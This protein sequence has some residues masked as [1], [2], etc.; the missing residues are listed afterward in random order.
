MLA[1]GG[2]MAADAF[3]E[4][5]AAFQTKQSAEATQEQLKKAVAAPLG[6]ESLA[7]VLPFVGPDW[8]FC[9]T[10]PPTDEKAWF[11]SMLFAL[12]VAAGDPA[13]P[14][15]R[16]IFRL[17]DGYSSL[18]LMGLNRM[19][20]DTVSLKTMQQNSLE[21]RYFASANGQ[22]MGL[23]PAFGLCDGF[24]VIGSTPETLKRFAATRPVKGKL[25]E[26]P[27]LRLSLVHLRHYLKERR[28]ALVSAL[29][30]QNKMDPKQV[31]DNLDSLVAGLAFFDRVELTQKTAPGQARFTLR[32]RPTQPFKK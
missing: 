30:E 28:G 16:G 27:L 2:R 12:R 32:L 23:Q 31:A 26:T 17:L 9:I 22:A 4:M 29:A 13:A 24:L 5:L 18:A 20:K 21:I 15:D 14:V 8:G 25:E 1:L 10:A 3:L 6:K 7:D 11:P 19:R